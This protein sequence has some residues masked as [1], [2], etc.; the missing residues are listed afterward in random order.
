M[1]EY[2]LVYIHGFN[3]SPGSFKAQ[4]LEAFV[5]L[6]KLAVQ[7]HIP[8]LSHWPEQAMGQLTDLLETLS[9]RVL[10]IGSSLGGFYSTALLARYPEIK[11]VLVNPAVAA[12]DLLPAYLGPNENLY[13]GEKYQLTLEH[14]QQ[15]KALYLSE[16]VGAE[17][18]LVLLQTEDETLDYRQAE[19]YY[20]NARLE[21]ELGGNHS[22][23]RFEDKLES[24]LQFGDIPYNRP[25]VKPDMTAEPGVMAK[26]DA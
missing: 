25:L 7:V 16:V 21:I 12:H 1:S 15:L 19:Q 13:T 2:H 24:I 6:N 8:Q 4:Q 20:Q 9:G 5:Q 23:E 10:L 3:S 14:M 17:R 26:T 18:M 22:F 11:A